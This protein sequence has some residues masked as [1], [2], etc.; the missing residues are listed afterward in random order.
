MFALVPWGAAGGTGDVEGVRDYDRAP[1]ATE[2]A[3]LAVGR[4]GLG[5]ARLSARAIQIAG[6]LV[7][8]GDQAVVRTSAGVMFSLAPHHALGLEVDYSARYARLTDAPDPFDQAGQ[9][10]LVYAITSDDTFGGGDGGVT[11]P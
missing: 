3:E 7:G 10:R 4:R 8:G 2:I 11:A 9:I 5:V 6:K 1:G